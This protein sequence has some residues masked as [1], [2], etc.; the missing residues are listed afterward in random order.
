[1]KSVIATQFEHPSVK[2][3]R[4]IVRRTDAGLESHRLSGNE[5]L[6]HSTD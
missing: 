2:A 4:E 5:L 1:M 3:G 6:V